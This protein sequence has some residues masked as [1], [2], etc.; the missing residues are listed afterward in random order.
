M[1]VVYDLAVQPYSVGDMLFHQQASI[2]L[3]KGEAVDFTVVC[4]PK[5]PVGASVKLRHIT[6]DNYQEHLKWL[7]PVAQVNPYIQTVTLS[8]V[9]EKSGWP[10]ASKYSYHDQVKLFAQSHPFEAIRPRFETEGWAHDYLLEHGHITIQIRR[11]PSR[12]ARN[13]DYPVWAEFLKQ[14]KEKFVIVCAPNEVD[15]SLRLPNVTIASDEVG[16]DTEKICALIYASDCHIGVNSG[17]GCIKMLGQKPFFWFKDPTNNIE[18]FKNG[19]FTWNNKRQNVSPETETVKRIH[20]ELD[21]M[22]C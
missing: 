19:R 16:Q 20:E 13:S 3:R 4:N 17:P 9:P 14:R 21:K 22:L 12:T 8:A 11:N 15:D 10:Y 5:N 1:N 6:K 2:I 18:G 7:M